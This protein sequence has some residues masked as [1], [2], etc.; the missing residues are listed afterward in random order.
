MQ[1]TSHF[2][3]CAQSDDE[4]KD[5]PVNIMKKNNTQELNVAILGSG[6]VE[7]GGGIEFL[8]H[9]LHGLLWIKKE[10][11]INIYLIL[12]E[13]SKHRRLNEATKYILQF[14]F[15]NKLNFLT[16]ISATGNVE[17]LQVIQAVANE[18]E[19]VRYNGSIRSLENVLSHI[20]AEVILP[21]IKVLGEKF[22]VPWIGYIWDFQH[23]YYP[24]NFK[25]LEIFLRDRHFR[26]MVNN[27]KVLLVNSISVKEDINKF[28]PGH[29]S[30]VIA[31]PFLAPLLEE[32]LVPSPNGLSARYGLPEKYFLISNQFWIHKSH[33]AAFKALRYLMDHTGK[34]DV[35]I[36]CT[37]LMNDYR[38]PG[39][40]EN[41]I[42]EI[43]ELRLQDNILLLG[44]IPKFDQIC[45]MK[46]CIAVIQ[47]TLFEGGPG[48][49]SVFD[50]VALGVP[51]IVSDIP[52]NKEIVDKNV[53]FFKAGS[54]QDL[55][56]NM[57][58]IIDS[59]RRIMEKEELIASENKRVE[60]YAAKLLEAIQSARSVFHPGWK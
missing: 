32:W 1:K 50:A 12:E 54:E 35:F 2:F 33:L 8:R 55:Y 37:G 46:G 36:V 16:K 4:D 15:R 20:D 49:G 29:S 3:I 53:S 23:R 28:F 6:F 11:N 17:L 59:P 21:C 51:S 14:I 9:I 60:R 40:M 43:S 10:K 48:G 7:W 22:S 24:E 57:L 31:L 26:S 27:A 34:K 38:F 42:R 41:L 47:P 19:I 25:R 18:I 52:V 30:I 56:Q 13:E 45:I 58:K 39:Y 5:I 44:H